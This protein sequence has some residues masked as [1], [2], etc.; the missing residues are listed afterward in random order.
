MMDSISRSLIVFGMILIVAGLIW[1]FS[2]GK[3]PLGKLPGDINIKTENSRIFIPI[4]T[5]ILVSVL[6]SVVAGFFRK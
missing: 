2:G 1:H 6:L 4:T 3:I 5:S